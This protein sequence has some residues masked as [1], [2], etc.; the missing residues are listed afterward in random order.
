MKAILNRLEGLAAGS[1]RLVSLILVGLCATTASAAVHEPGDTVTWSNAEGLTASDVSNA[2]HCSFALCLPESADL[3]EGS[4]VRITNVQLASVNSAR[5]SNSSSTDKLNDPHS[6]AIGAVRSKEVNFITT[7]TLAGKYIDSYDFDS[8]C[9]VTVGQAYSI[10]AGGYY[11]GM[12]GSGV[13]F[14]HSNGNRWSGG[15]RMDCT[16]GG[17][18]SGAIS[19]GTLYP[20]YKIT[21]KVV[22]IPALPLKFDYN[23]AAN[24]VTKLSDNW[25]SSIN[26]TYS[27]YMRIGSNGS[28]VIYDLNNGAGYTGDHS[29]NDAFSFALY[30][31]MYRMSTTAKSAIAVFGDN[32]ASSN[33]LI[34]YRDG[35][36]IKIGFFDGNYNLISGTSE[37]SVKA[38]TDAAFHLITATCNPK[39]GALAL[40]VDDG[41]AENSANSVAPSLANEI[42]IPSGFQLGSVK[43]GGLGGGFATGAGCAVDRMLGFDV[44]LTSAQVATL[45]EDYASKV[46]NVISGDIDYSNSGRTLTVYDSEANGNRLI[47]VTQGT[48]T[49]A[50][51]NTVSVP[52]VRVL[53]SS[54]ETT[55]TMNVAGTLRVT[56]TSTSP[57]VWS[58]RGN[59]KG[60]LF[61]HWHGKCTYN[62]TGSL[63]GENAYLETVYTA[64]EQTIN[65][66]GGLLKV[67]G[68]SANNNNSSVNLYGNGTLEVSEITDSDAKIAK[69]FR[70]GTFKVNSDATIAGAI[71]FDSAKGN[72]TKLDPGANTLT[73]NAAVVTGTGDID[74]APSSSGKVVL[75]SL[76]SAYS[77]DIRI[78]SGTAEID[79]VNGYTGTVTV[80][81]GATLD[82]VKSD[83]SSALLVAGKFVINGTVKENGVVVDVEA[84]EDGIYKYATVTVPAVTGAQLQSVKVGES[85]ITAS[86]DDYR[87]LYGS[88]VVVTWAADGD[89]VLSGTQKTITATSNI[90][91]S[92]ENL[93][94]AAAAKARLGSTPCADLQTAVSG[95]T[96]GETVTL[97]ANCGDVIDTDGCYFVFA[98]NEKVFD[99]KLKGN[100]T[101]KITTAPSAT[102][103][104]S[105]RFS[106]T[107]NDNWT[108]TFVMAWSDPN[109]SKAKGGAIEFD[110]YG[111]TGSTVLM[112]EGRKGYLH[113]PNGTAA[114]VAPAVKLDAVLHI[115]DGYSKTTKWDTTTSISSLSSAANGELKL[116]AV[117]GD[118][119]GGAK[120][121]YYIESL[122]YPFAG[123][124]TV[125]E[126]YRV[127]IGKLNFSSVESMN[128]AMVPGTKLV[129]ATVANGGGIY[130]NATTP[131]DAS[132]AGIDVAVAG[133]VQSGIKPIFDN[134]GIYVPKVKVE[135]AGV[136]T[137]YMTTEA[138][139]TAAGSDAATITLLA[140]AST[141]SDVSLSIGQT[142]VAGSYTVGTVTTPSVN[143]VNLVDDQNGTWTVVDNRA[144][145]WAP[146]NESTDW[147]VA[148][149]WSTG[150]SPTEYT[151]VMIP[152]NSTVTLP[153]TVDCV[154][155]LLGGS[156]TFNLTTDVT[157]NG[158][159]I[160]GTA[161]F[162]GEGKTFK[163]PAGD[164]LKG[165]V[166]GN[167]TI[168][169]PKHTLPI[170]ADWSDAAWTGTLVLTDCG[171]EQNTNYPN[172]EEHGVI[173]FN[174]Y[175]NSGSK[176]KAPGYCGI[177]AGADQNERC[178]A[179]LIIDADTKF[180]LNHGFG[181]SA[182]TAEGAG[183]RF[184]KLSGE[185]ELKLDGTSDTAQYVFDDVDDFAGSVHI[186]FPAEGGRKSFLFGSD[187]TWTIGGAASPA[188]LVIVSEVTV[189]ENQ[190]WTI[191]AGVIVTRAGKLTLSN[192]STITALSPRSEGTLAVSSGTATV[193]G[194]TNGVVT[195]KLD[196]ASGATL[197]ITDASLETL[198]I[199][200]GYAGKVDLA[201]TKITT[202][203]IALDDETSFD[204]SSKVAL[205]TTCVTIYYDIGT[206]RDLT[207][208]SA[209]PGGVAAFYAEETVAEYAG[210][211]FKVTNVPAG[212]TVRINRRSGAPIDAKPLQNEPTT[213]VYEGGRIFAGNACWHEYDFEKQTLEDSGW[214]STNSATKVDVS[215]TGSASY[216]ITTVG[217][218][219]HYTIPV[220]V[221]PT[222]T[223]GNFANPWGAAIRFSMPT[224]ANTVA[225]AFG[226][227]E[228]GVLGLA[229]GAQP[230]LVELFSWTNGGRTVLARL[231]VESP[232]KMHIY[233]LAVSGNTVS[234]YRDGE[235][236]HTAEFAL[237][238]T[239]D[240][241]MVGAISGDNG[242]IL[243]KATDGAV[244]YVR[245]YDKELTESMAE[246]LSARRPFVSAHE[247]YV[248]TVTSGQGSWSDMGAW[249]SI[250]NES[251]TVAKPE[252]GTHVTLIALESVSMQVNVE[253]TNTYETLIFKG[254]NNAK[255]TLIPVSGALKAGMV[256]VRTP[257]EV[258]WGAADFS[259]GM[260]GV[261]QGASLVFDLTDYPFENVATTTD[262]KLTGVV[263]AREYD[264]TVENRI[265]VVGAP[266]SGF[267]T[268]EPK[269]GNDS[270]FYATIKRNYKTFTVEVPDNMVVTVNGETYTTGTPLSFVNDAQVT[271]AYTAADGY[272]ATGY[273]SQTVKAGEVTGNAIAAT[274]GTVTKG[275][276]F[277]GTI[278]YTSLV[279]AIEGAPANSTVTLL[280]DET[281]DATKT[282]TSDRLVVTKPL[283]ID[284]GA[285]TYSVPGELEPTDNWC[286]FYIDADVTVTGTTGGV[287]CL[288]KVN[289]GECGVYAFNVRNNAKLTI[290]GGHYHG[291]GTIVQAQLG[292][293]EINGGTFTLTPFEE[294]Y[295]SNF[296]FN[297]VDSAYQA[298]NADFDIKGGTFVGFDPQANKA[299]GANTDFTAEG[300]IAVEDANNSGTFGVVP[301]WVITFVDEDGTTLDTQRVKAGE[302]PAY[303]GETPTKVAT[304]QYTY[305]FARWSPAI[306]AASATRT[307]S[308]T[309]S[310]TVNTYTIKWVVEGVETSETLAY[311]AIPTKADPVKASTA[312]WV[313]TFIGW[314]PEVATVTGNATYTAQFSQTA[315]S[316]TVTIP[317]VTGATPTVTATNGT[318]VNNGNGTYTVSYGAT[319]SVAWAANGAYIVSGG[320]EDFTVEGD[321]T[322][323]SAQ[324]P[325]ATSAVAQIVGGGYY[326][327]LKDAI[328]S[329]KSGDVINVIANFATDATKTAVSDRT[330]VTVP[331]TINF[332]AY[333][334]SVPGSLEPTGNWCALYIDANTTING[335][336]GGIDCL[337]K[338]APDSGCG[339]YAFNV[340]EGATLT[341]EGGHYHGGGTIVQAQLGN[342]VVNG[343]TFTL[344]PF[345]APYGSDFAFNCVD[346]NYQAGNAGFD[347]KGGTFV[348]FDPQD[349]KAEGEHTDF[350]AEG[351]IAVD[352][353]NGTFGIVPGWVVTFLN[354][355]NTVLETLRVPAGETPE[356]GGE[357]PVKAEDANCT[358]TFAGWNAEIVAAMSDATYTAIFTPVPKDVYD[359]TLTLNSAAI[360]VGNTTTLTVNISKNG[361]ALNEVAQYSAEKTKWSLVV[362]DGECASVTKG[363]TAYYNRI[364]YTLKGLKAGATTLKYQNV[365]NPSLYFTVGLTVN[366]NLE[367]SYDSS[368]SAQKGAL[369]ENGLVAFTSIK[370][371][372]V[373]V[374]DL[375]AY[376]FTSE[377]TS[378]ATVDKN[379]VT[380]VGVGFTYVNITL[381]SD[382]TITLRKA[383]KVVAA[384]AKIGDDYYAT[385]ADAFTA[386]TDGQTIVLLKDVT[387]SADYSTSDIE[388]TLDLNGFTWTGASN[389]EYTLRVRKGVV[390]VTDN[391]SGH[392]GAVTYGKDYAFIVD[393][394][395]ADGVRSQLILNSGTFTGKTSVV[396]AGTLGGS[397]ANTK[398]YGG[399]LVVNGGTFV[400][401]DD[402]NDEHDTNGHFKYTLNKLDVGSVTVFT[403]STIT[404]NGGTFQNFDPANN[405]AE[406]TGTNFVPAGYVSLANTPSE[407][408]Y[409]VT[410][411]VT[412][413][414]TAPAHTVVTVPGA[415]NNGD[416]TFTV[417]PGTVVTI[418][419]T[420]E[421]GY[422]FADNTTVKNVSYTANGGEVAEA[423]AAVAA[424]AK[425]N[426][427]PYS[428]LEAALA[429]AESGNTVTLL[430]DVVPS[431]TT[432]INGSVTLDLG[433]KTI[434]GR[435]T[436]NTG[437]VTV[438]NGTV[439]GRFDA[440]DDSVVTLAATATVNGMVVVWGDGTF[441]QAGCK[442]P[443]LN[444]YGTI[445][446]SGEQAI[447]TNGTDT[448][449]PVINIYDGAVVLCEA[450]DVGVFL[451]S[452]N[453]T[454]YGGTV[455][456]ATAVYVK[457]GSI[458]VTGGTLT[459]TGPEHEYEYKGDGCTATGDAI[460]I[461][462]AAYPNGT[463][464]VAISGGKFVSNNASAIG[465]YAKEGETVVKHFV[466]GGQFSSQLTADLCATGFFPA[467]ETDIEGFYGVE[468]GAS[469]AYRGDDFYETL[470]AALEDA[471]DG[472]TITLLANVAVER[473]IIEKSVT[474]DLGGKKI[475]GRVTV[476]TGTVTVQNGA[477]VGRFDAYDDSVVTLA[478]TATVT[479]QVVV[480]GDGTFGAAGCKTPTLNVYGTVTYTGD[481]AIT[482]NGT[483]KSQAV[484][485]VYTGASVTS[486]DIAI[487]MPSGKLTVSG[488]TITGA[489][490]VYSKSG[491]VAITGGTLTGNGEAAAYQYYGNGAYAT[492]D[493]LVV[494]SCSY[495]N[496]APTA[497]VTGGTLVSVNAKAIGCYA[498]TGNNVPKNIVPAKVGGV[499]NAARFKPVESMGIAA[500]YQLVADGETGFFKLG[501][502]PTPENTVDVVSVADTTLVAVPVDCNASALVNTTNRANGDVLKA[503]SKANKRYYT[504]EY[505]GTS[506]V[507]ANMFVIG[508]N[509]SDND[510]EA[511]DFQLKKGEAVWVTRV[512]SSEPVYVNG[513][514]LNREAVE[515]GTAEPVKVEVETGYNLV[516]PVPTATEAAAAEVVINEV[517]EKTEETVADNDKILV[518]PTETSAPVALDCKVNE[519]TGKPEWGYDYIETYTDDAGNIR[520]RKVRKTNVKIPSGTGFWYI[521]GRNKEISL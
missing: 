86:G 164:T 471:V 136:T 233:A 245:L 500:G 21:A 236:I 473:T 177:S 304:A 113:K 356:Y 149:N 516:A 211:P 195:T 210:T 477:I 217:N 259:T 53:N 134:D 376:T 458:T 470:D 97:L 244:D 39:T 74:V 198:T 131:L 363:P 307:Y 331:L 479:G 162:S 256:V 79:E 438:Q 393:H 427:T 168:E 153:A 460:V 212:A 277:D 154:S 303:G 443:T 142:L 258:N 348:G 42:T 33:K 203:H 214:A 423:E 182:I 139:M 478:A 490:A 515:Q 213:H 95:A 250:T 329:A 419:Y 475:T 160:T 143:G 247:T 118:T 241:F 84:K 58:E 32:N 96:N 365:D 285:F 44:A 364:T 121:H 27:A 335:T 326:A 362:E 36:N 112:A 115:A 66:N 284:F 451:P 123:K 509:T 103:W 180:E 205:P 98:E 408:W 293:V 499:E 46:D 357:T 273:A 374:E 234:L 178:D 308:A 396:Q 371:D 486:D 420:A 152:G 312:E 9:D 459:G 301:G 349:N 185:G 390:T 19:N 394:V 91:L 229:T 157:Y 300:F 263:V 2:N 188:N 417:A 354:D 156:V 431:A 219:D 305:E 406:G 425:I 283:T 105:A 439:N 492:G 40:Y 221:Y 107:A 130:N 150:F 435:V 28:S 23:V 295:G 4:V 35:A 238:G 360:K 505:N 243:T 510:I 89:Y 389:R 404:V 511:A 359:V 466:S 191:P 278:Y 227:T 61:G 30:A 449:N 186:T 339:V 37:A 109:A 117:P 248:R 455:T 480:W 483:D 313:Y 24:T 170:G 209:L 224:T 286:A 270:C 165:T 190:T 350:T 519:D 163:C 140:D 332:G 50:E 405:V 269:W 465:V 47:G 468:A 158:G 407:G 289:D 520:S 416:G 432:V 414:V 474:L 70:W 297:C 75:K 276:A 288:D 345:E 412:F 159:T 179:T 194:V 226:D 106:T 231:S 274:T 201:S 255:I 81:N 338:V 424:V 193:S 447:S 125:G 73:L 281:A 242:T 264:P 462:N 17:T 48:L 257:V 148:A 8:N 265:S 444:V 20:I 325:T 5:T 343:G 302:T 197:K 489:T 22:S 521:S 317:V 333:T 464:V 501:R 309:Y 237:T 482:C 352:G 495:P 391:S 52:H 310:A 65:V 119:S 94:S 155:I 88:E 204:L 38:P 294:P 440:Y 319:V 104:S 239:I 344:T 138:A 132:T 437:T 69:N 199:P 401:V 225:I 169:Y 266:A 328:D 116:A 306:E 434:T 45:A 253:S 494:E 450:D 261:D 506:W 291:G 290:N 377:D 316:Y 55:A 514:Y 133:V 220:A 330:V 63:I 311:G 216:A 80:E 268:V 271:I 145:I 469:V 68:L 120:F 279:A 249:H 456:G 399:D 517:V 384:A 403:P 282:T 481:A 287:N 72:F 232:E 508:G 418:V 252:N 353:G 82:I 254:E 126:Y 111:V 16:V 12:T 222:A 461:D 429:A 202:L 476:N 507:R 129:S 413:A 292:A 366:H 7:S 487:Y 426:T 26:N 110:N 101:I 380:P 14:L 321:V 10:G 324:L 445:T 56:S 127:K 392:T 402:T 436:V 124:I 361:T 174:Q 78:S 1:L 51:N 230:G 472:D 87:V 122:E 347:I 336:T 497:L 218:E 513:T 208:Y 386:A 373:E 184:A 457:S 502:I 388:V 100:G 369:V 147:S 512:D 446:N 67:K 428:S 34:L 57:D 76:T 92:G 334:M 379:G 146:K 114:D 381:E 187:S 108:G 43:G 467:T 272:V 346:A 518:P 64:E 260:L 207:G 355:D 235:F 49:I 422:V 488:G 71:N 503:Y 144:S 382:P 415:T 280:A 31:D 299:E 251:V 60:I 421:E 493:A 375:N 172:G 93:I 171:R 135:K 267:F 215:I 454:V 90:T 484:I 41:V 383:I 485:N 183:F 196:I 206:K 498:T 367:V 385:I 378:I 176:I 463:P 62:I 181:T 491:S 504:W 275:V 246:G 54:A 442:T 29:N 200:A 441:G 320:T 99:G 395:A 11:T 318:I 15:T 314:T 323:P 411:L 151:A 189:A 228:N 400:T 370:L 358:Y 262:V 240:K 223:V 337:D 3:P 398:Y 296:A 173:L 448:S 166:K 351:F 128:T 342:V 453:L 322:L 327:T 387:E 430:A 192:G 340:R 59:Y 175:G 25:P 137:Y 77:G 141:T 161:T 409:T 83:T 102:T 315:Q 410:G 13:T 18:T 298:G 372:G 6:I 341:I 167:V 397:G 496:G 85:T 452:G 368:Y 433:G